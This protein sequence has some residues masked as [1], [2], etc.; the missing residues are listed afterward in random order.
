MFA[1]INELR[2]S[3]LQKQDI[4][5]QMENELEV[6]HILLVWYKTNKR[7][8]PWRES[9][10]P[11]IIWISE[12]IL[13]QTRVAQGMD[14][15]YRFTE[16]FPDVAS[17]AAAEE[18]EV[19]KYW[20][21]LGYYSRARNLHAA[22]KSIMERF[23]GVFPREYKEILSLKGIGEYTA[24]AIVSFVWNKPYPVVDGNVY[25][26]LSRLYAVDTP[27]DST[28]GKKQFAELAA[29]V[30]N[31]KYAGTHNQAIMEFGALQ[32]VPQNPDCEVCPLKERCMA[33]VSGN[34]Q[35]FPVK[36]NKTKTRP[37]YFHYLYIIYKG[38]TWLSRRGKKDIWEGLYEFPLIETAEPMDF[39]GLQQTE[40]YRKLFAGAGR[41]NV[42]VD[43]SEVKHVLSHQVLYTTFYRVEIENVTEA[44]DS[45]LVVPYEDIERYAVPRLVHIYL[46]KLNGNLSE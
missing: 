1:L 9:S 19:L 16:R 36:Q 18:D 23:G 12:I 37:R 24:A 15:F 22:A 34:V 14:Y 31:P 4:L 13:Q 32:C 35:A 17:L 33:Y 46:E 3:K 39:A 5:T 40:A 11:Y 26:V 45:Y 25:R 38:Q 30:M 6:S 21:G 29:L 43:M 44:L 2:V 28:Q 41:M 42:S 8:L 27:I 20:Q 10:D 7:M